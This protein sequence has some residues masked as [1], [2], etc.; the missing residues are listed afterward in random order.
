MMLKLDDIEI[1]IPCGDISLDGRLRLPVSP[2]AGVVLCHP[3]PAFGGNMDNSLIVRL[4]EVLSQRGYATL[5]FDFRGVRRSTGKATGGDLEG[6][7]V[8]AAAEYLGDQKVAPLVAAGY[9]F[10]AAVALESV[11]RGA[12]FAGIACIGYTT[13][14]V[15]PGSTEEA[16]MRD[17]I[18]KAHKLLFISGTQDPY[19]TPELLEAWGGRVERLLAVGHFY[20]THEEQRI[21]DLVEAHFLDATAKLA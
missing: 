4:A 18:R 2:R 16:R 11:W 15:E 12:D 17:T 21:L 7:D 3:H 13:E 9:S 1:S 6:E 5:R 14:V 8:L 19:S 10:G 20:S